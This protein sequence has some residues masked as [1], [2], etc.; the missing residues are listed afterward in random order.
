MV[1]AAPPARRRLVGRALR[2]YRE[3][4]GYTLE[5]AA[6][7]L[8][9]DWS[10]VSRIETG[11]RGI[12]AKELR[13]LLLHF[14]VAAEQRAIL[15]LLA[16]PRGAYGWHRDYADVLPSAWQ[17]YFVLE[18]AA[19]KI[20]GYEAQQV[21]GLLQTPAY[22]RALVQTDPSLTDD[23]ARDRAAGA[24]AARQE[25]ILGSEV[26]P[27]I[28]LIIGEAALRQEVGSRAVMDQ[29]LRLL[30]RAAEES[31][32][33]TLQILPFNSGAHAAAGDGSLGILQFAGTPGLGLVH[34]GGISGGVCRESGSELAA[35][36]GV[37]Q[38]LRA[39]ALSPAESVRLLRGLG[40]A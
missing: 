17:D 27:E 5:D 24:V 39:F 13:E 14:G 7:L 9:C 34:V 15:I 11:E 20:F 36:A 16:D 3:S 6:A 38:Q 37:F 40:G 30:A 35:Y 32:N 26:H 22:A 1:T 28:H 25:A 33:L 23:V 2:G 18:T 19:S 12:R 10:K 4:L 29:Q 8:E 21:P 31:G